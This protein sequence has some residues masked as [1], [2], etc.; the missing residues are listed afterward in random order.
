MKAV[1]LY[2][3]GEKEAFRKFENKVMEETRPEHTDS[4]EHYRAKMTILGAD[5]MQWPNLLH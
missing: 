4:V 3:I 2:T 5:F 1:F